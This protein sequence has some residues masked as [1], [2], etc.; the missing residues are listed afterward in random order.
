MF[1][2]LTW[3]HCSKTVTTAIVNKLLSVERNYRSANF[4]DL[5]QHIL[6]STGIQLMRTVGNEALNVQLLRYGQLNEKTGCFE[7]L[8]CEDGF[9]PPSQLESIAPFSPY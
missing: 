9:S 4:I 6:C 1:D 7:H 5:M 8:Q 2:I 3:I